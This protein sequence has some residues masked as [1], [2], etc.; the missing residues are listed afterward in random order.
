MEIG[1]S[2]KLQDLQPCC[3]CPKAT[4]AL[5]PSSEADVSCYGLYPFQRPDGC[6]LFEPVASWKPEAHRS[7][8]SI[9]PT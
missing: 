9:D 8:V 1:D 7:K 3:T 2:A 4:L 5:A 6:G